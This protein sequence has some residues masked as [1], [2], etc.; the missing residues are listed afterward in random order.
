MQ[1]AKPSAVSHITTKVYRY[2]GF[3]IYFK[4]ISNATCT[5]VT[6]CFFPKLDVSNKVKPKGSRMEALSRSMV[7]GSLITISKGMSQ[8]AYTKYLRACGSAR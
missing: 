4:P 5:V 1:C 8:S 3:N 6:S 2:L 7:V